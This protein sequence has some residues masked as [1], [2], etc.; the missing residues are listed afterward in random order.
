L[1]GDIQFGGFGCWEDCKVAAG[2]GTEEIAAKEHR[3]IET[4]SPAISSIPFLASLWEATPV[5]DLVAFC[6]LTATNRCQETPPTI[7]I[8]TN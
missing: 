1:P 2:R 5:A 8:F 3:G 7:R 6:R 4:I